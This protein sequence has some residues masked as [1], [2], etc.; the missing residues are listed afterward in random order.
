MNVKTGIIKVREFKEAA[1]NKITDLCF[2]QPDSKYIICSSLD[3][4]I[5]AWDILT[6]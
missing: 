2:S 4:S 6:G 1:S 3:K 5:R